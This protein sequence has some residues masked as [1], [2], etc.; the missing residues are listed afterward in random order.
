MQFMNKPPVRK[1]GRLSWESSESDDKNEQIHMQSRDSSSSNSNDGDL[2]PSPYFGLQI[3][4]PV[5]IDQRAEE[6]QRAAEVSNRLV[7][8]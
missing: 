8:E 7:C 2:L 3:P 1:A 4:R 6:D 5:Q